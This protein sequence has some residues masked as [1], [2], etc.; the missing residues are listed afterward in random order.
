[1]VPELSSLGLRIVIM[2]PSNAGKSTLAIAIS[3]KLGIPVVHLDQL[4]HLPDT[5]WVPRRDDE[6]LQLHDAAI[7]EEAWV[8]DGNYTALIGP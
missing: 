1:M 5:D 8:M 2:G 6:F 3:T 7:E 4:R